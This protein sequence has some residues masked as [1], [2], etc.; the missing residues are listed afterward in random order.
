MIHTYVCVPTVYRLM[1]TC[2]MQILEEDDMSFEDDGYLQY[3][4]DTLLVTEARL[5]S[6][7]NDLKMDATEED[8][9]QENTCDNFGNALLKCV[10]G[11]MNEQ[12]GVSV[13]VMY[14]TENF[15]LHRLA[16]FSRVVRT[17]YQNM[18]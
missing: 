13:D 14:N 5:Q 16:L 11:M 2:E 17:L 1:F 10:A 15:G 12:V 7:T 9:D 3:F 18:P 8:N 4:S 6:W